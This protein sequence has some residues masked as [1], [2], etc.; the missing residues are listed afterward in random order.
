MYQ[1][2]ATFEL[3]GTVLRHW[4]EKG[5]GCEV[6]SFPTRKR[7]KVMGAVVVGRNPKWHFSFTERFNGKNL[8]RFL[9][10]LVNHYQGTKIHMIV[11]N[12]CFHKTKELSKWLNNSELS[13]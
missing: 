7:S 13:A 11:D 1:D 10:R 4:A 2:E 9:K 6:K 12:A 3:A 8:R 5:V